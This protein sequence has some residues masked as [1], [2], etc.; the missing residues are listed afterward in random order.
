MG[1]L[2][3]KSALITGAARGQGRAHAVLL[4]QEG[5][6][7]VLTDVPASVES[8]PYDLGT[9]EELQETAAL[10]EKEGARA[11]VVKGDVRRSQDMREAVAAACDQL[12]KLD[13]LIANAGIVTYHQMADMDD[14]VWQDTIDVNLTGVANTVRA[15]LPHMIDRRYGRIVVTS[16]AAARQ[17]LGN[18][19]HY[20]ASKWGL[21]GMMKAVALEVGPYGG[22]TC[23]AVLP[24]SVDTPMMHHQEV[25]RM[26][27]PELENPTFD[28]MSE[29]LLGYAAMPVPLVDPIDIS[30][31]VLYLVSDEAR[32]VSGATIDVGAGMNARYT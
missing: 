1:K 20:C 13:I 26:F 31:A 9:E 32:Y 22:I 14:A 27:A 16:S 28:D 8:V 10:V 17:G 3:G 2:D 23:N 25:Y 19:G 12:G 24:G 7:I 5:A 30:H 18:L 4:A 15:A 29:R 11:L 6:D 21:L